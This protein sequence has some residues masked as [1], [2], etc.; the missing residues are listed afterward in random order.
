[1]RYTE[2]Y[3]FRWQIEQ[4]FRLLKTKGFG[5]ESSQLGDGISLKKLCVMS[6]QVV[7]QVM[8]LTLSRN[9]ENT[10]RAEL[11]FTAQEIRFLH[12]LQKKLEGKTEK[13]QN[14]YIPDSL[15]WASWI[16]A[17][18]GGWKGLKSQSPP[19]HI[20]MKTGLDVFFQQYAGWKLAGEMQI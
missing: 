3:A 4:L 6:L 16:I 18:L 14:P 8:Q 5:I 10:K 11:I 17:R 1:M 2:W 12:L 9:G 19:G 20:T 13:L 7:L 15:A